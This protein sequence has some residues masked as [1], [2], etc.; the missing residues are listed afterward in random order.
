MARLALDLG[1]VVITMFSQP[2]IEV[3][4]HSV[5]QEQHHPQHNPPGCCSCCCSVSYSCRSVLHT[6]P[7][8]SAFRVSC[9]C[10]TVTAEP[11]S[12]TMQ[13]TGLGVPCGAGLWVCIWKEG[14]CAGLQYCYL[15]RLMQEL[16]QAVKQTI[17]SSR[18]IVQ[19]QWC[20]EVTAV[21]LASVDQH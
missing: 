1:Q 2:Q 18:R 9:W 8:T 7:S 10:L 13:R 15:G 21:K 6:L 16:D 4:Q 14:G 12:L 20:T 3:N 17:Y 5:R 11:P 19:C